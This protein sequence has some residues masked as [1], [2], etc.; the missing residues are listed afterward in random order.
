MN[1][2]KKELQVQNHDEKEEVINYLDLI[3]MYLNLNEI[4]YYVS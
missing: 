2:E 3:S 4:L 1:N